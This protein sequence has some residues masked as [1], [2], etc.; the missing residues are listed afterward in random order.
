[1]AGYRLSAFVG[2]DSPIFN[3]AIGVKKEMLIDRARIA[4]GSFSPMT[5]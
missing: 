4:D 1:M 3:S 2:C 5:Y